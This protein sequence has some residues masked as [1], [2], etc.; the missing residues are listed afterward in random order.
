MNI[1]Q[2]LK[3]AIHK[4]LL[5]NNVSFPIE[6][7]VIERSRDEKHGDYATNIAMQLASVLKKS[8]RDIATMLV[9]D[10]NDKA[11]A[12]KEIA[13]PGFINFTIT[14]D[15]LTNIIPKIIE[16]G[17]DFGQLEPKNP[18]KINV[19]FVSANPTGELHLGH[20][21]GAAIG[22]SL[23]RI[24]AKAGHEVTREYYVNDAGVQIDNLAKSVFA[25]YQTLLGNP[26]DVPEDGYHSEHII[27]VAQQLID[28]AGNKYTKLDK[29]TLE[30]FKKRSVEIELKQIKYDLVDFNVNFDV[31]TFE[32]D[33]RTTD[34]M[35]KLLSD[36]SKFTYVEEDAT[37]LK[38]SEFGDDK[39][40]VIV[41]SNGDYTYFLPDIAYHLDKFSRNY[42]L[43]ID[44]LGAD[45]H[46]YINRM[47]AAMQMFG[48][49]ENQLHVEIIQMVRLLEDGKEIK[50]S[51]RTGNA[52]TLHEL[53]S[54]V[55]VD[56]VRY[57]FVAR[58]ASTHLD[59]DIDL[60]KQAT[61][62]NPLYY[63]QYAHARLK[64]VLRNGEE[65]EGKINYDL[66]TSKQE[67]DLLICL[68]DFPL[69][70]EDAAN[71]YSPYKITVYL[72]R[73]ATLVHSF[74]TECRIIQEE[75]K[76]LTATRLA[77]VKASAITLKNGLDL[78]G[79]KAP[80]Y[81]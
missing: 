52:I 81:M 55:G 62:A 28:E 59:F 5:K 57:F 1:E 67:N 33:I 51:K 2:V 24:L 50:M 56:A 45:H 9:N 23:C 79:V 48:Y 4:A 15:Y 38:T 22:D 40:R 21:R 19:E 36:L 25:R 71:S 11:I 41:K 58:A 78:I 42:D 17:D 69:V 30:Y 6:Q 49:K 39:D 44:V 10:I 72:Q 34:T 77:L 20:A 75:N 76:E 3:Q 12:K 61:N 73:L 32:S 60:A 35:S 68:I 53:C 7:I 66:L 29:D 74:Y 13:G 18:L 31:F 65:I 43:L 8:P 47:K 46:G 37:L 70:V 16:L 64:A 14:Q 26:M 27:D 63:V 80:E 54:E